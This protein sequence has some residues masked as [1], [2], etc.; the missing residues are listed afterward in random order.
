MFDPRPYATLRHDAGQL[1]AARAETGLASGVQV[2]DALRDV[3]TSLDIL[4]G[5]RADLLARLETTA[6]HTDEGASTT[7][8]WARR[9]LRMGAAE[10]RKN[11]RAGGTL[12]LLPQVAQ[13]LADGR[14]RPDHVYEFTAGVTKLGASVMA[15]L[16]EILLPVAETCEPGDLKDT[17]TRL[18]EV[19]HPEE[20]DKKYAA[21]MERKDLKATK[22]GDG[23]HVSGFLDI[24]SGAKFTAWLKDV[25]GPEYD[26]DD[27]SPAQRR[28]DAFCRVFETAIT[29]IDDQTNNTGQDEQTGHDKQ[30]GQDSPAGQ[31]ADADGGAEA[32]TPQPQPEPQPQPR[33]RRRADTRLLVL[34]DLETLLRLP[35]AQPATLAGFGHIGQQLLGYLTCGADTAGILTHGLTGG[36]VPQADILNVGRTHRLATARQR[37]AVLARQDGVCAAPG[38]GLTYL[39]IHHVAWWDRDHGHT[40][41]NNLIGICGRCHHLVHQHKL[42][43]RP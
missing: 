1:A 15:D 35:G 38:C 30:T 22:C 28:V 19:L 32:G 17:I 25:S 29:L 21:G 6:G 14:I 20:L 7:S 12:Q 42:T 10:A 40:D 13:A 33:A 36:P 26:G 2:C 4:G 9:E 37:D 39:E 31:D 18:H 23:Y 5:I 27:R 24:I 16:E 43:I 11:C 3:Q 8:G 34:A 41:L